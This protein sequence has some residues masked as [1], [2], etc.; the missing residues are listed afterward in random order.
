MNKYSMLQAPYTVFPF[1]KLSSSFI[2]ADILIID[3][4][5]EKV[6]KV[7]RQFFNIII[8][9]DAT[10]L[11]DINTDIYVDKRNSPYTNDIMD[12]TA[13]NSNDTIYLVKQSF[14]DI[15]TKIKTRL[16]RYTC[17]MNDGWAD[18][19]NVPATLYRSSKDMTKI[20]D[21]MAAKTKY[22][23]PSNLKYRNR[24]NFIEEI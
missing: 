1:E 12:L 11:Y 24:K 10:T 22:G 3:G 4:N 16:E 7:V 8:T 5:Y 19:F 17:L 18:S 2:G 6:S 13:Y 21:F 9:D 14:L 23:A 20:G 15:M